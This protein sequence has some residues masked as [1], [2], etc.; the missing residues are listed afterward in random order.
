VIAQRI[1]Q[2]A[3]EDIKAVVLRLDDGIETADCPWSRNKGGWLNRICL[4]Q[5]ATIIGIL[6]SIVISSWSTM[7][8]SIADDASTV[9]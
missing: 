8:S 5:P 6:L 1:E 4:L 2:S 7:L 3:P 9:N